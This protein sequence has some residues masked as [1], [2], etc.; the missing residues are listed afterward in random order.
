MKIN[1]QTIEKIN[2]A[3]I[4]LLTRLKKNLYKF[5]ARLTERKREHQVLILEIRKEELTLQILQTI[6]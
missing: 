6:M 1:R 4:R 2:T 3:K 5:L